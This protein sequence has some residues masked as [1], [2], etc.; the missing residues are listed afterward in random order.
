MHNGS[1]TAS[2]STDD[3]Q[4]SRWLPSERLR[5][6]QQPEY[7]ANLPSNDYPVSSPVNFPATTNPAG[8]QAVLNQYIAPSFYHSDPG[9]GS[10]TLPTYSMPSP[11]SIR[12]PYSYPAPAFQNSSF[13]RSSSDISDA[14]SGNSH[15]TTEDNDATQLMSMPSIPIVRP[16]LT[17]AINLQDR[18]PM[19][20]IQPLPVD[21]SYE[22]VHSRVTPTYPGNAALSSEIA[23]S[24]R[25]V[26]RKRSSKMHQCEL[27]D[28]KFPR[29]M[30]FL[31]SCIFI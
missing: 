7:Q 10:R 29:S 14:S 16:E 21:Y 15:E 23:P 4:V 8:E 30:L 27:C 1:S 2:Y 6:V 26:T 3:G 12:L 19:D 25:K 31:S 18:P 13:M 11:P 20:S 9:F 5:Y 17:Y 24:S 22:A 28:K